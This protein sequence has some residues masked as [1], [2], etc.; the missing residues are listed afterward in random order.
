MNKNKK[1]QTFDCKTIKTTETQ[2][3]DFN[4]TGTKFAVGGTDGYIRVFSFLPTS[5]EEALS[6][7]ADL[8]PQEI[9]RLEGHQSHIID[10]R[11]SHKDGRI[12][13]GSK[14]GNCFI[15]TFNFKTKTWDKKECKRDK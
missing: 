8:D 1:P 3:A 7:N 13:S 6:P 9:A 15:W 14:D 2:C 4:P 11:F 10:V 12:A 5:Y